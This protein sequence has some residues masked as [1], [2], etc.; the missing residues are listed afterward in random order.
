MHARERHHL[1]R[2]TLIASSPGSVEHSP[3]PIITR[4]GAD[5]PDEARR[6]R[7]RYPVVAV[8]GA[9]DVLSRS[10]NRSQDGGRRVAP[11]SGS[12]LHE[13]LANHGACRGGTLWPVSAS[14]MGAWWWQERYSVTEQ[15]GDH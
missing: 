6:C 10:A 1:Q 3:N 8:R 15:G 14:V 2:P 13:V 7:C 9:T 11:Q 4:A 5:T 12:C